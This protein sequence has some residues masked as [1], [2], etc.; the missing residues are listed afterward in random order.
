MK[1]SISNDELRKGFKIL[2]IFAVLFFNPDDTI[3]LSH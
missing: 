2:R 1:K 3:T